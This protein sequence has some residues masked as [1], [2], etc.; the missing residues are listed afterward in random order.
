MRKKIVQIRFWPKIQK[1]I[2]LASRKRKQQ[3][4]RS[5]LFLEKKSRRAA[6]KSCPRK[7][8]KN[9][10]KKKKPKKNAQKICPK[11]KCP[12]E[13]RQNYGHQ[14]WSMSK[15]PKQMPV[16]IGPYRVFQ[17]LGQKNWTLLSMSIFC[18]IL[19][20]QTKTWPIFMFTDV[21]I[22]GAQILVSE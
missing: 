7:M 2:F 16:D 15:W 17:F 11:E 12:T 19:F 3:G 20:G 18:G 8:A 4:N 13:Q 6:F 14:L 5:G 21:I 22:T 9:M 1:K 10:S